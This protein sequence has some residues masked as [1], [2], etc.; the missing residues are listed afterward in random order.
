MKLLFYIVF[1]FLQYLAGIFNVVIF[2]E[3]VILEFK[4][5]FCPG[6]ELVSTGAQITVIDTAHC[7]HGG[8]SSNTVFPKL[9]SSALSSS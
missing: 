3:S 4:V 5:S 8:A 9:V 2:V 6:L 7:I 1:I